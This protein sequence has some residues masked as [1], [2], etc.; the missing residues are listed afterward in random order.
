[1]KN[2]LLTISSS[3]A[4]PAIVAVGF[5]CADAGIQ[6][7]QAKDFFE[8]D[9]IQTAV[10]TSPLIQSHSESKSN[11]ELND[12]VRIVSEGSPIAAG[13]LSKVLPTDE[14][15]KV[16]IKG[17]SQCEF[18]NC[19]RFGRIHGELSEFDIDSFLDVYNEGNPLN[20][21]P[22]SLV[23]SQASMDTDITFYD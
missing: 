3:Y 11:S 10:I 21:Y 5:I 14:W 22:F 8:K 17:L 20:S 6:I 12:L 9:L 18:V 16:M 1:M 19:Y 13:Y 15:E 7:H 4:L 23:F 2:I